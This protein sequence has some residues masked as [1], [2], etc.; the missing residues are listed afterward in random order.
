MNSSSDLRGVIAEISANHLGSLDRAKQLITA[1]KSGGASFV[2][3]QHYR[4]DTITVRGDHPDLKITGGTL[5]DGKSLW[6]LYEEAMTPWEWTG[7]LANYCEELKIEWFSSPF[8]ETAIEFLED[9]NPALY[10]IASFEIVDLP[11]IS[12]AA[13][14][15]KP[16]IISTGMASTKEIEKAL[17][18]AETAGASGITLLRTNSAYPAPLDEMDLA[19]ISEMRRLWG[20]PVGLSDHTLSNTAAVVAVGLGATIFEKHLTL[21]RLDGG[22]DASFSVEPREFKEYVDAISDARRSLGSVRFG[23]SSAEEKSLHFRPSL[24]AVME[25]PEGS[26]L[27]SENVKSVRPSG[28]L[29][30]C[31]LEEIVG[32][33]AD[34]TIRCG[35]PIT[36]DCLA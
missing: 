13:S 16:L 33:V 20:Y 9:F 32:R 15:G 23:P 14:T 11:L 6:D 3:F 25:I 24:R 26:Q 29:P 21:S 19:A 18:A 12:M 27:T 10:K 34:K 28:G 2:K 17:L 1:A 22:P 8:D 30:P 5:W 31:H 35:E 36:W 4:P 7:E